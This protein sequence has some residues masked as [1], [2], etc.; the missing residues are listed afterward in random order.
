MP[1]TITNDAASTRTNLGLGDAATKTVG[2]GAGNVPLNSNLSTV[3]TSGAYADV[4]GTPTL[5][6][7]AT[8]GA[9]ADVSG[10]PTFKTVGGTSIEGS[11]NIESLPTGGS[12]GQVVTNTS[13]G[14]GNWQDAG[15]G[16]GLVK[17]L[18]TTIS[19]GAS[20][21]VMDNV[22]TSAYKNYK[23]VLTELIP[24][25]NGVTLQLRFRSSTGAQVDGAFYRTFNMSGE[26]YSAGAGP[27]YRSDWNATSSEI[28]GGGGNPG[29]TIG[30]GGVNGE[31]NFY[32][33]LSTATWPKF[34]GT[35]GF[36]R[37]D[38]AN[39]I[40]STFG[41]TYANNSSVANRGFQF[42]WSS[43]TLK[44]GIITVYGYED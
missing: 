22:F 34:T 12:P 30:Y 4:S 9:Y 25:N 44:S 21:V 18:T 2:T 3:A 32:D 13:S 6:T 36:T 1:V 17:I 5:S 42:A 8:S 41:G 35:T 28:I 16:G 33:P 43:G 23:V 37:D 15:G 7:V 20:I 24:N 27:A 14:V 39:Y 10:T 40:I 29:W 38:Q 26:V 11:G 19:N 31:M